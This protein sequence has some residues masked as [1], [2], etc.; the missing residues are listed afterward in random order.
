MFFDKKSENYKGPITQPFSATGVPSDSKFPLVEK[1][2]SSTVGAKMFYFNRIQEEPQSP[3]YMDV[4]FTTTNVEPKILR[5]LN[6]LSYVK[7]TKCCWTNKD[8]GRSL[9]R[10]FT[11]FARIVEYADYQRNGASPEYAFK[12]TEGQLSNGMVKGF[13]RVIDGFE[14]KVDFGMFTDSNR[15]QL[16]QGASD[17]SEKYYMDQVNKFINDNDFVVF[18]KSYCPYSRALLEMLNGH[19][20]EGQYKVFEI[21]R[22]LH[23]NE[24]HKAL[25][26]K[27]GR[28]T[29]PN[30]Y[31]NKEN[32][33]GDEE[34]EA[35]AKNGVLKTKLEVLS[36]PNDL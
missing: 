9:S 13:A 8:T 34:V 6:R 17:K 21:D 22:E 15:L 26:E 23:G 16:D 1:L 32:L 11:G 19:G 33:G 4:W 28:L 5:S 12:L 3:Y 36:I 10:L 25:K 7:G 2:T 30:V 14:G 35:M 18:T 29:I 27:S 31:L 20:L 24:V